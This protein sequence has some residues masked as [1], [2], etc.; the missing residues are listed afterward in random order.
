LYP[1]YGI[2][3]IAEPGPAG[4]GTRRQLRNSS[5]NDPVTFAVVILLIATI[6]ALA[7]WVPAETRL[8]VFA[9][10]QSRAIS[11]IH[12]PVSVGLTVSPDGRVILYTQVDRDDNDLVI[13][14][15][16][17]AAVAAWPEIRR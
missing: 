13:A 2:K 11:E 17:Q 16:L 4:G 12:K 6:G 7:C 9:D 14:R 5:P 3:R 1:G 8:R 15:M 10:G